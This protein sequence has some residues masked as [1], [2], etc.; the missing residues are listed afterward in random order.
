MMTMTHCDNSNRNCPAYVPYYFLFF[1]LGP[2]YESIRDLK[3]L[4]S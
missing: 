2:A 1:L 4:K 3:S